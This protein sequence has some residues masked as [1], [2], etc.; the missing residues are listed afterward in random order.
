MIHI[1]FVCTAN[2]FRSPLAAALFESQ[3]LLHGDSASVQ[4]SS[5]GTW[6][7]PDLP[8]PEIT[9]T[10]AEI[11]HLLGLPDHRTQALTASNLA[12]S[13]LVLVM[14]ANQR[15]AILSEFP[16]GLQKVYLLTDIC[17]GR[18]FDIPDPAK[19][20]ISPIEIAQELATYIENGYARILT[21]ARELSS[22]NGETT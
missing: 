5:A 11:L 20:N 13:D 8:A 4:V 17:L 21:K 9:L 2:Q 10:A 22:R 15:E 19:T 14:E 6:A 7:Q 16:T 3:L 1:L 18:S 12:Q